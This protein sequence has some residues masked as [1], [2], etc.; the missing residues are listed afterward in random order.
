M[1]PERQFEEML[2]QPL[3]EDD[4]GIMAFL[5]GFAEALTEGDIEAISAMWETPA[6]VIADEF[7][8]G[9]ESSEELANL[10]AGAREH[11]NS[12]GVTNTRPEIVRVDEITDRLVVV[13]VRWP[14]ID[15]DGNEMGAECSTY[16]L[17]RD[18]GG[19]WKIRLAIMHGAEALH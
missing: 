3:P 6:M 11:Y 17:R 15:D 14:W 10:F 8:Q 5:Q 9:L 1:P 19:D 13:R 12:I 7:V 18:S 16:T 2:H 4:L